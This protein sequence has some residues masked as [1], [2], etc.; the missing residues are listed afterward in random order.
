MC[1]VRHAQLFNLYLTTVIMM[2]Y[3][4][5]YHATKCLQLT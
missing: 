3:T 1:F 2:V 4:S 5:A